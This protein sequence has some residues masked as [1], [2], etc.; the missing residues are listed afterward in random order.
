MRDGVGV[1][2]N[3]G[4]SPE[5]IASEIGARRAGRHL[6]LLFDFDGTL[7]GFDPDPSA[8]TLPPAM[9]RLLGSL[10]VRQDT[11]VG[12]ISGRRLQDV[13]ARVGLS[14]DVYLAG[15]HGLEIEGG[16]EIFLHPDAAAAAST[17]R[18]IAESMRPALAALP[19][20]FIED[21]DYSIALHMREGEA[22]VQM[23]AQSR[24]LQAA[25]D[26]LDAGRLRLQPGAGVLELLPG[27][28]W[29]KGRALEWIRERVVS[30]HGP[31]FTVYAG[32]DVTDEDAFD[33]VG[34]DGITIGASGR[35]VRATHVIDGPAG[36]ERLLLSLVQYA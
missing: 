10:S 14:G 24:F 29:H 3:Q 32:D 34:R 27:T 28:S 19:G 35:V 31:V 5:Q 30:T 36:V 25:R 22:A 9:A 12:I 7:C 33:A 23:A 15:F 4:V 8:V 6:L 20:V 21:K 11:T 1:R 13:R 18:A 17:V 16:G 2:N 26:D